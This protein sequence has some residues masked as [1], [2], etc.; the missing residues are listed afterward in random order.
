MC[1]RPGVRRRAIRN[2]CG[3]LK[4]T[5]DEIERILPVAKLIVI[6]LAAILLSGCGSDYDMVYRNGNFTAVVSSG[7]SSGATAL[8]KDGTYSYSQSCAG[9]CYDHGGV[10]QWMGI[11]S[12]CGQ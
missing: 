8:C 12:V 3:S 10:V 11:L 6:I 9:T 7:N 1:E 2:R 5:R 4:D